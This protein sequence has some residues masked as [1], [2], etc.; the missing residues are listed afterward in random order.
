MARPGV[1]KGSTY[2]ERASSIPG[3]TA[4]KGRGRGS[5]GKCASV[6]DGDRTA[7]QVSIHVRACP[8]A[9]QTDDCSLASGDWLVVVFVLV[10]LF[11][12]TARLINGINGCLEAVHQLSTGDIQDFSFDSRRMQHKVMRGQLSVPIESTMHTL[13]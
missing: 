10:H 8:L 5:E 6:R 12:S 11:C 7:R 1:R 2:L 4:E 9:I 13:E 3:G